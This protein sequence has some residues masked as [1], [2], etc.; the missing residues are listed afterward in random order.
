MKN[1]N[2]T[3]NALLL[4]GYVRDTHTGDPQHHVWIDATEANGTPISFWE[5]GEHIDS[6]LKFKVH[7][8]HPDERFTS[9]YI[10]SI[11]NAIHLA[12]I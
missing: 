1:L 10:D 11:E 3:T 5:R 12:R 6:P 4:A 2:R 7:G 8:W 9:T